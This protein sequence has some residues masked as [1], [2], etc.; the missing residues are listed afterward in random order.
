V[1]VQ[2]TLGDEGSTIV[3]SLLDGERPRTASR[4]S[5]QPAISPNG[6]DVA[7]A[8]TASDAS[9]RSVCQSFSLMSHWV[10]H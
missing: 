3:L 6:S 10:G 1:R 7:A 8:S 2:K 5:K 4:E 9:V